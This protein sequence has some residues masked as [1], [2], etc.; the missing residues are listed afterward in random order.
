MGEGLPFKSRP[1]AMEKRAALQS[2][3]ALALPQVVFVSTLANPTKAGRVPLIFSFSHS[4]K[5]RPRLAEAVPFSL[6]GR[7]R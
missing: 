1:I 7:C 6:H 2:Q 4:R 5:N 3:A